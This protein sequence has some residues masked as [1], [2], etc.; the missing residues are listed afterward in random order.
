MSV[1]VNVREDIK[2]I[3]GMTRG[4]TQEKKLACIQDYLRVNYQINWN[5]GSLEDLEEKLIE[6]T[7]EPDIISDLYELLDQSFTQGYPL[8][9]YEFSLLNNQTE[10]Y[11][12]TSIECCFPLNVE[13]NPSQQSYTYIKRTTPIEYI[14]GDLL[15]FSVMYEH[16]D[17]KPLI[18]GTSTKGNLEER[19]TMEVFFDFRINYCFFKCGDKKH[20]LCIQKYLARSVR[21]LALETFSI[22]NK[23][24]TVKFEGEIPVHKQ[25]ALILDLLE[26]QINFN[27]YSINDYLGITFENRKS[28][29][30][31]AVKLSGNNLFESYE[32]AERMRY[33]DKIKSI[34]LQLVRL[35]KNGGGSD[36]TVIAT[37]RIDFPGALKIV[38]TSMP[39]TVYSRD[40]IHHIISRLNVTLSKTHKAIEIEDRMQR[41][42]RIAEAK[43]S[44]IVQRILSEIK[45]RIELKSSL[46]LSKE[47]FLEV[48]A[49]YMP[50]R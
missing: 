12:R 4:R 28:S 21:Y 9:I 43:D 30:V 1:L 23:I 11:L 42:I 34:K 22:T 19:V 26:E 18:G 39:N 38:F 35:Q 24:K 50:M 48:L 16:Y 6:L 37:V 29:K 20:M 36:T 27:N 49:E 46:D 44:F 41:L 10:D 14:A 13:Y 17:E 33:H 47:K 45:N 3:V 15:K 2:K 8:F 5:L 32:L 40:F 25:T 7:N 31:R